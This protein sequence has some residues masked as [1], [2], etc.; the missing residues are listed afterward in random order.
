MLINLIAYLL[1]VSFFSSLQQCS[2]SGWQARVWNSRR[3]TEPK[4]SSPSITLPTT[5]SQAVK[6]GTIAKTLFLHAAFKSLFEIKIILHFRNIKEVGYR[7]FLRKTGKNQ[8]SYKI[9]QVLNRKLW[10]NFSAIVYIAVR[11]H[12]MFD[13]MNQNI[14]F[15]P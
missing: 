8:G 6:S 14:R 5:I 2:F 7:K 12:V 1:F 9:I 13:Y 4:K 15:Y 3:P 11:I 10:A